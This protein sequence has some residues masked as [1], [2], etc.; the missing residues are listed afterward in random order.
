MKK[1]VTHL[2]LYTVA[3]VWQIFCNRR[4]QFEMQM[5]YKMKG[6]R[7]R[8]NKPRICINYGIN[9]LADPLRPE[10]LAYNGPIYS[11]ALSSSYDGRRLLL[12]PQVLFLSD[13]S[14]IDPFKTKKKFSNKRWWK[15]RTQSDI[16]LAA[17][18]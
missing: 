14:K 2:L 16:I 6:K 8:L 5:N 15:M 4:Y 18:A 17:V 1:F 13:V 12:N 10:S 3:N 11:S 7:C 9:N